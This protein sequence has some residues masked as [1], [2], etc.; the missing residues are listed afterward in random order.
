MAGQQ[1]VL[2][3]TAAQNRLLRHV[4]RTRYPE[5]DLVM[6]LLSLR[7]G[8]RAS[9]IAGLK[10]RMVLNAAGRIGDRLAVEDIIAKRKGGRVIPLHPDLRRALTALL[11]IQSYAIDRNDP[12]IVSERGGQLR[13]GSVVNLFATW[14][15][16]LGLEGCSSHSGRRTFVTTAARNLA[17]VGGSLRDVQQLAGHRQLATTERYIQG[18]TQA[19]RRLIALM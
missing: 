12:V 14:Y 4:R 5:R 2:L 15:R 18:D 1:A 13:A 17:K 11:R 3:P 7:A 10:W 16:N 8:L 19:Q 9:E 6:V